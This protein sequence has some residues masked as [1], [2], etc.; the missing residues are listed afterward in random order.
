MR[1]RAYGTDLTTREWIQDSLKKLLKFLKQ[2]QNMLFLF[3]KHQNQDE[4]TGLSSKGSLEKFKKKLA[5]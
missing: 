1:S 4:D 5:L 3:D 2:T